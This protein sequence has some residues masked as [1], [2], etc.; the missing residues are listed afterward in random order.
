M[1]MKFRSIRLENFQSHVDTTIE[2]KDGLNVFVGPSDSGKSAIFRGIK[3]ALFNEPAGT[4]FIRNGTK[5]ARVTITFDDGR[6]LVRGRS[7]SS[8]YYELQ[9]FDEVLRLESFG[10][11]VPKEV[12]DFT[13]IRKMILKNGE[14]YAL[15]MQDQLEGPFLLIGTG[16]QKAIAIGRLSGVHVIDY[17]VSELARELASSKQIT[18][19]NDD[20]IVSQKESLKQFDTLEDERIAL[21]IASN[22]M[23]M[24]DDKEALI[25]KITEVKQSLRENGYRLHRISLLLQ[26]LS[27]LEEAKELTHT[28]ENQIEA[29]K[30]LHALKESFS[31]L[32]VE[33]TKIRTILEDLHNLPDVQN[34]FQKIEDAYRKYNDLEVCLRHRNKI[35]AVAKALEFYASLQ[36]EAANERIRELQT[37]ENTLDALY[38]LRKKLYENMR[39]L[40]IGEKYRHAYKNLDS[41]EERLQ[42]I[43]STVTE[44]NRLIRIQARLQDID[45][46]HLENAGTYEKFSSYQETL[47]SQYQSVLQKLGRCPFC[48]QPIHGH[49]A[50]HI[51]SELE[52]EEHGLLKRT[53]GAQEKH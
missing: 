19:R 22:E 12:T 11:G 45:A 15:S 44:E 41:A 37:K 17:A 27:F 40:K 31:N 50:N 51:L 7:T 42:M 20:R 32:R 28:L 35:S 13:N 2:L 33:N 5:E 8:N 53:D 14:V 47:L 46:E 25:R 16:T 21:D 6:V 39:R 4:F 23:K 43:T 18:K 24:I 26:G 30:T 10:T 36:V 52:G 34:H 48:L 9:H 49:D 29:R 38:D 3:W 1:T